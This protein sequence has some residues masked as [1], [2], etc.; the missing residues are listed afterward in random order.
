[1]QYTLK[2]RRL[3]FLRTP[4]DAPPS[5]LL[6]IKTAYLDESGHEGNS[7]VVVAG[8][9][10][11]DD[12]WTACAQLWKRA[13]APR[14]S[15]HMNKLRWQ[16]KQNSRRIRDLLERHGP[17]PYTCGLVPVF[18]GVNIG[19]YSDLLTGDVT[20]IINK[21]YMLS[22]YSLVPHALSALRD[23]DQLKIVLEANDRYSALTPI[24]PLICSALADSTRNPIFATPSGQPRLSGVEFTAKSA[25][26]EPADYLAFS[27]LQQLRDAKSQRARWCMPILG[28]GYGF[29]SFLSREDARRGI[30]ATTDGP[31]AKG[32]RE[33]GPFLNPILANLKK[34][35]WQF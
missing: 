1:M 14:H 30:L 21:G 24:I 20:R 25:L 27:L 4:H 33:M 7:H 34:K 5:H 17:I 28:S 13:L 15:L 16:S 10:G 11:D 22:L 31:R 26:T 3:E 32:L 29:G 23:E 35:R 12:Q 19:D 6:M 8:F 18:G 2:K 9:L